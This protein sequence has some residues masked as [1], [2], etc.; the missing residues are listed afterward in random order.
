MFTLSL[1]GPASNYSRHVFLLFRT[2]VI[3]QLLQFAEVASLD[4]KGFGTDMLPPARFVLCVDTAG[5]VT[6]RNAS[7]SDGGG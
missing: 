5:V 2:L 4:S 3:P 6:V 1:R 7:G